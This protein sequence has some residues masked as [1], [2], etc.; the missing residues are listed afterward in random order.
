MRNQSVHVLTHRGE[1]AAPWQVGEIHIGGVGLAQGYLGDPKRTAAAFIEHPIS[2]ERLYRTGDYGRITDEGVI[3]LLGRRDNQIKIRGHRIELAEVDSALCGLPGVQTALSTV[4]GQPPHGRLIAAAVIPDTAGDDEE[5]ERRRSATAIHSAIEEA[6]RHQTADLD[7][8]KLL[9]FASAARAAALDSMCA[10]LGTAARPAERITVDELVC[11]LSLPD[12]LHRLFRRWL[13]VLGDEGRVT[14]GPGPN[15]ELIAHHELSDCVA[16]W[17]QVRELGAAVDYGDDLLAYVG[18]CIQN[19]PGL[20]A[21][22]VDPLGL[23]FP[24]GTVDTA[25]AAYRD[26]LVSRYTNRLVASGVA[27]RANRAI[28]RRPLR[29]LEVGAGVAGTTADLI[30][31]LAPHHVHYTF[32]DVSRFFLAQ[33]RQRF[34]EHDFIDCRIFDIN[35]PPAEQGFAPCSFDVA[36]CANV[37]HNA[38]NI[39]DTLAM[40]NRVLAPGGSLV[41]IDAT[42][43]NHPLMISMEF[44]EGLHGFTDARAGT[45]SAFFSYAQWQ[46]ALARSPFGEVRSF[47]PPDHPLGLLGQHV[48]WCDSASTAHALRP[49]EVIEGARQV[50]PSYMVPQQLICLPT[51]PLT[52]NGKI[53]RSAVTAELQSLRSAA[54]TG[55]RDAMRSSGTLDAMQSRIAAIWA[56]VL[57]LASGEALSPTSD[58]FAL[59]GDSLLM[60]QAIGRI[61]HEIVEASGLAWDDL[62][63]AMVSNP[64]LAAAAHAVRGRATGARPSPALVPSAHRWCISV[65]AKVL[66]RVPRS[67]SVCTTEAG[68]WHPMTSWSHICWRRTRRPMCTACAGHPE[69]ATPRW[70]RR[71]CSRH[72]RHATA[73]RLS[74]WRPTRFICSGTAWAACW[75]P[76]SRNAWKRPA[77]RSAP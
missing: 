72:W 70:R 16:K 35:R 71:S 12:G 52:A 19:L 55:D 49:T 20:L 1:P 23:F 25:T 29:V 10:A 64:T 27:A 77:L 38:I 56:A 30:A 44:K 76:R 39:D 34:A 60:A 66:P 11:R 43:V 6:H 58:F 4:I 65:R 67:R 68:D 53:D 9:R 5:S 28:E 63:R 59:G 69:T 7:A 31:A 45:N 2:G 50:L 37:L 22:V 47:P 36:I 17:Q 42:A 13:D 32:T 54:R 18:E 73:T 51:L 74:P 14:V 57:G 26:N 62:L 8:E 75:R 24:E 3:E 33:A 21:G 15:L 41:F 40:L 46:E 48:F 61:R